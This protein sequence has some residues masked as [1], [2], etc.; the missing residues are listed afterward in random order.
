MGHHRDANGDVQCCQ[1][2]GCENTDNAP[3]NGNEAM[4]W[5][6]QTDGCIVEK[7]LAAAVLTENSVCFYEPPGPPLCDHLVLG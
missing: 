4:T 5:E 1:G 2:W 3:G 6:K 7:G